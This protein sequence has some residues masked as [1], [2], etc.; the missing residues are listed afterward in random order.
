MSNIGDIHEISRALGSME[1]SIKALEI[2][3][4]RSLDQQKEN[5]PKL[6]KIGEISEKLAKME[7]SLDEFTAL[8]NKGRGILIGVSLAAGGVGSLLPFLW[9][10][11]WRGN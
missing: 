8:K 5:A 7:T 2:G 1:Q 9:D 10:Y 3:L 11:L 6:Q 4:A